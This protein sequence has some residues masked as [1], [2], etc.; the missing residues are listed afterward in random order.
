MPTTREHDCFSELRDELA[1]VRN[2]LICA[3][4]SNY[5]VS[6]THNVKCWNGHLCAGPGC[7]QRPVTVSVPIPVQATPEPGSLVLI[8]I[9]VD[10]VFVNLSGGVP[11]NGAIASS[12]PPF[13]GTIPT[14]PFT[15]IEFS[16]KPRSAVLIVCF[17]SRSNSASATPGSWKYNW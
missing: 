14:A 8:R 10:I 11:T 15:E 2:Q 3:W 7:E 13:F 4:E 17:G 5:E 1:Q 16:L 9:E 12:H 6:V